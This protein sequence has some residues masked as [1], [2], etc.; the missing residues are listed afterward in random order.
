MPLVLIGKS[1]WAVLLVIAGSLQGNTA[2]ATTTIP[3]LLQHVRG[4]IS[5]T[6]A[7]LPDISCD[8]SVRSTWKHDGHMRTDV[9][10][11]SVLQVRR[12]S[13]GDGDFAEERTV[14]TQDGKPVRRGKLRK[15]PLDLTNGFGTTFET[16]LGADYENCNRYKL[17]PSGAGGGSVLT[18]QVTHV[19]PIQSKSRCAGLVP[20]T[21]G[22]FR[23][24]PHT[25]QIQEFSVSKP[26]S[27][28]ARRQ[29]YS[30]YTLTEYHLVPLGP[31][32]FLL[33]SRIHD[34]AESANGKER[35]EY[36]A[37]YN[38]CHLYS[39]TVK[40]LENSEVPVTH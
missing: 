26:D 13:K 20:G 3:A 21:V 19:E 34:S 24:D 15:L 2:T 32:V 10:Q 39:S 18:L 33:P 17:L 37:G 5:Q 6:V 23:I 40:L 31:K 27:A 29:E 28:T 9:T 22:V 35:L 7:E 12:R 14:I 16:Y 36:D 11:Q 8:E 4:A 25:Y 1:A 38:S 30:T